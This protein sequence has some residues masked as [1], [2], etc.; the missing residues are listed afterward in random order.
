[1]NLKGHIETV[2]VREFKVCTKVVRIRD[3][4]ER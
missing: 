1:M 2:R 4:E 3:R